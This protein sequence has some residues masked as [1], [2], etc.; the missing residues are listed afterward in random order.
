MRHCCADEVDSR[1][2]TFPLPLRRKG[3]VRE[4]NPDVPVKT[5]RLDY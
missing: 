1:V 4:G 3:G 2:L 5:D